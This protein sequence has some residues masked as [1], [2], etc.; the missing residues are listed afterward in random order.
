MK[1]FLYLFL[2]F[3]V[4]S[5]DDGEL[6]VEALEFENIALQTCSDVAI[7]QN[8][9]LF[10]I[11]TN[12]SL[13][14]NLAPNVLRNE[15]GSLDVELTANTTT[16]LIYRIFSATVT[17]NYYCDVLPPVAPVVIEEII[18]TQASL[19]ITTVKTDTT[20]NSN[21]QHTII[22]QTSSL[23]NAAGERVTDLRAQT[24]GTVTTEPTS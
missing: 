19:N 10:K 21:F 23:R 16:K 12:E 4:I 17:R 24:F 5:C 14:L 2:C 18:A 9:I 20:A 11:N 3:L 13:I 8:N 1:K 7:A 22:I 6:Q 15:V